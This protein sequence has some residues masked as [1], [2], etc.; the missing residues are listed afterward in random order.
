MKHALNLLLEFQSEELVK[1]RYK[2]RFN[3]KLN[4]HKAR[5]IVAAVRQGR[6][7][8][9]SSPSSPNTVRPL[10]TYY[11][12]LSLSRALIMYLE[13][14]AEECLQKKHG[15]EV[16]GWTFSNG[17]RDAEALEVRVQNGTF[18]ELLVATQ[19]VNL[20][21]YSSA[22][23][24]FRCRYDSPAADDKFTLGELVARLPS[25]CEEY[26]TWLCRPQESLDYC[27]GFSSTSTDG[28]FFKVSSRIESIDAVLPERH[29]IDRTKSDDD[30]GQIEIRCSNVIH[31]YFADDFGGIKLVKHFPRDQDAVFAINKLGILFSCSYILGMLVRYFPLVSQDFG[32]GPGNSILPLV[33]RLNELIDFY[34]AVV[35]D[36]L[37]DHEAI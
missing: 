11:G 28:T 16:V 24:N 9:L 35:F 25:L 36:H 23:V 37:T 31:P 8:F 27:G 19:N 12:V 32:V 17:W 6:D 4:T 15:L 30:H 26:Q 29:F 21:R 14:K 7:F 3:R 20:L 2:S 13:G 10:L 5:S 1:R 18:L 22:D 34:P 33:V